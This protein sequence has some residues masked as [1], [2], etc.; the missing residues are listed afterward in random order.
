VKPLDEGFLEALDAVA[1]SLDDV[2]RLSMIIGGVALIASGIPRLTVNVDATIKAAGLSAERL[3]DALH[4]RHIEPRIRD[5]EAFA[6]A[7][8]V[9][10]AIHRPSGIDVDVSLAWLPFEVEA[11]EHSRTIDYAG[12]CIRIP[13]PDDLLIYK[14]VASRP[15]DL[16]DAE[17]LLLLHG[18]TMNLRRVRRNVAE[19]A[20]ALEDD[21]RIA[22]L[23]RLIRRVQE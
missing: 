1:Q 10:L 4:R 6:T 20:N 23:E 7:R 17:G 19:F 21:E 11:L 18:K 9:F 22:T 13:R 2:D 3:A 14:L 5:A 8:Q 15:Q 12:V 16:A